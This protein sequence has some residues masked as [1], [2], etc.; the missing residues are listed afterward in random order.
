MAALAPVREGGAY[1]L[2]A[3]GEEP[4]PVVFRSGDGRVETVLEEGQEFPGGR[5]GSI[6]DIAAGPEAED[7]FVLDTDELGLRGRL[8]VIPA[9]G[10]PRTVALDVEYPHHVAAGAD[11]AAYVAGSCQIVRVDGGA[12]VASPFAGLPCEAH[13]D[14]DDGRDPH[15]IAPG[16]EAAGALIHPHALGVAG[17]NVVFAEGP[18]SVLRQVVDGRISELLPDCAC[19]FFAIEGDPTSDG[20]YLG[21]RDE[22]MGID[23][24]TSVLWLGAGGARAVVVGEGTSGPRRP[25]VPAVWDEARA[26]ARLLAVAADGALYLRDHDGGVLVVGE[27]DVAPPRPEPAGTAPVVVFE[28]PLSDSDDELTDLAAAPDGTL[29]VT[30]ADPR[31]PA[32]IE[33]PVAGDARR[34]LS[35]GDMLPAGPAPVAGSPYPISP[36]FA[37]L[38]GIAEAQQPSAGAV[39]VDP[40]S[41]DVYVTDE[42]GYVTGGLRVLRAGG[43]WETLVPT[44]AP[45]PAGLIVP[46]TPLGEL[47]DVAVDPR[48]GAVAVTDGCRVARLDPRSGAGEVVAGRDWTACAHG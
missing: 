14:G 20:L 41:G 46:D 44:L 23:E 27:P 33:V 15:D 21:L 39:A 37:R 26:P 31:G 2:L 11:D 19:S 35:A 6:V 5:I 1:L 36:M 16:T 12:S 29:Y 40:R 28:N 24:A 47:V 30:L 32:V 13:G 4:S 22:E 9:E 8:R 3:V 18:S 42:V 38:P 17:G 48:S 45:P 25:G 34:I 43:G 7:L 10:T